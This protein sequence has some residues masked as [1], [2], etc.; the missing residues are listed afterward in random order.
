MLDDYEED[1]DEPIVQVNIS[2][3]ALDAMQE[4][5]Q[6]LEV[7]DIAHIAP[8]MVGLFCDAIIH[9]GKNERFRELAVIDPKT[10]QA[11][12]LCDLEELRV[13]AKIIEYESGANDVD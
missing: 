7:D 2:G 8:L 3:E 5:A 9:F 11:I 6:V 1:D 12:K 13:R 4:A 10:M